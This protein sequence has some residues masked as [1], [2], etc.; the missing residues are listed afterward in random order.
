MTVDQYRSLSDLEKDQ[1]LMYLK[2]FEF[3]VP[4]INASEFTRHMLSIDWYYNQ[5]FKE[6]EK[7]PEISWPLKLSKKEEV[8]CKLTM[9]RTMLEFSN[10]NSIVE[11]N[12]KVTFML[13][14]FIKSA[15]FE[16]YKHKSSLDGPRFS[17]IPEDIARVINAFYPGL[18][19]SFQKKFAV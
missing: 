9:M 4:N 5:R 10:K 14:A 6:R 7:K 18:I 13:S 12:A 1:A 15:I 11:D 17:G 19:K 2:G 3:E 8:V 16:V